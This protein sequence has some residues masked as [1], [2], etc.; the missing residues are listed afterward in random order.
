MTMMEVQRQ[1]DV[2]PLQHVEVPESD[3]PAVSESLQYVDNSVSSTVSSNEP[4]PESSEMIPQEH[5]VGS[6]ETKVEDLDLSL[7]RSP[8]NIV[9]GPTDETTI[10]S[11]IQL[12]TGE[13]LE[14]TEG[15]VKKDEIP[16]DSPEEG[17]SLQVAAVILPSAV[18]VPVVVSHHG[19]IQPPFQP[20]PGTT[21]RTSNQLQYIH[22]NVFKALWNHKFAGPFK[23]PVDAVRLNLPDYH[24]VVTTPMDMGTVKKRLESYYYANAAQCLADFRLMFDNCYRYNPPG[25]IIYQWAQEL[26]RNLISRMSGAPELEVMQDVVERNRKKSVSRSSRPSTAT[27]LSLVSSSSV[28]PV[29]ENG[30]QIYDVPMGNGD[31]GR[32][33]PGE[34]ISSETGDS[35]I[36]RKIVSCEKA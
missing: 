10:V 18:P 29:L 1:P 22:K 14:I 7:S 21:L 4:E 28:N 35:V 2:E 16:E 9:S 6:K 23:A 19:L 13:K 27:S 17:S 25:H 5:V 20:P 33:S 11:N 36:C 24:N 8:Q 26:D 3:L 34:P 30:D 12:D 15:E 31:E 32:S